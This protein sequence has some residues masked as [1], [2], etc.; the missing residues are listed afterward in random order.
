MPTWL[1]TFEIKFGHFSLN[2]CDDGMKESFVEPL[3]ETL[4][5]DVCRKRG[6]SDQASF[7]FKWNYTCKMWQQTCK[8]NRFHQLQHQRFARITVKELTISGDVSLQS[9]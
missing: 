2:D 5:D 7:P 4:F 1:K 6:A 3:Q 9:A 8:L